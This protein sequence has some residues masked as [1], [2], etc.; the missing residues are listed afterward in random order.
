MMKAFTEGTPFDLKYV[1]D[2]YPWEQHNSGTFVDVSL[3]N[4]T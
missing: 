1:T 4:Q 2:F 3:C